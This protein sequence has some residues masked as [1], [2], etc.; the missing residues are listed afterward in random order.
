MERLGASQVT[1][2]LVNS[3]GCGDGYVSYNKHGIHQ[4]AQLVQRQF[5]L[6]AQAEKMTWTT[7]RG[8]L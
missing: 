1:A 4:K 2:D 3:S 8:S 5:N 7:S 6:L